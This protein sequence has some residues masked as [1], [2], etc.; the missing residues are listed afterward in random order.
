MRPLCSQGSA[1]GHEFASLSCYLPQSLV[2]QL[3]TSHNISWRLII[4]D[5]GDSELSPPLSPGCVPPDCQE[6]P[7]GTNRHLD[8][9]GDSS[10]HR[11]RV[12]A[13]NDKQNP[14]WCRNQREERS[15]AHQIG[16]NLGSNS[17]LPQVAEGD[18][19]HLPMRH[20][21]N[22]LFWGETMSLRFRE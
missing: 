16:K 22:C 5:C 14:V 2:S 8:P 12:R 3:A 6:I 7:P 18:T 20:P 11:V 4:Q 9:E 17:G 1:F 13:S 10:S 19:D 15:T 21:S